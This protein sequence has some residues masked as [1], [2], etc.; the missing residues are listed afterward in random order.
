[1]NTVKTAVGGADA[2]IAS[3]AAQEAKDA[4]DVAVQVG[5]NL[6][7]AVDQAQEF[8]DQIEPALIEISQATTDANNATDAITNPTTGA[9]KQF[10]DK[11]VEVDEAVAIFTDV[12]VTEGQPWEA[13]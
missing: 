3:R 2:I 10:N 11:I 12:L 4:T 8:S 9:L 7:G 6:Q 5:E 1:M 13:V